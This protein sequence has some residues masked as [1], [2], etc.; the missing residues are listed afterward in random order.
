MNDLDQM[1]PGEGNTISPPTLRVSASKQWC[2]TWNNYGSD[3]SQFEEIL[4]TRGKYVFGYEIGKSGTP[5]LQG[6]VEFNSKLRPLECKEFSKTIHWEKKSIHS[7]RD[8]CIAY[9][10]KDGVY[11]TN[12]KIK[13]PLIDPLL[14]KTYYPWQQQIVNLVDGPVQKRKV[15]WFWEN[16]GGVG[17]SDFTKHLCMTKEGCLMVTGKSTDVK[18]LIAKYLEDNDLNILIIDIPRISEG[19]FSV[20]AVEEILNGHIVSGKFESCA[21]MFNPPHVIVFANYP[22]P[23]PEFMSADRWEIF[24]I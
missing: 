11:R 18:Y 20:T 12:M 4:K 15:H 22:P 19:H 14:G 13:K 16:R 7:T 10:C 9:C 2:F 21:V 1:A 5:H 17:K 3:V 23:N 8:Q 6:Y 24:E